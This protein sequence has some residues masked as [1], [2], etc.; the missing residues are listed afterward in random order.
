MLYIFTIGGN[1]FGLG[2]ISRCIPI[3]E[4]WI[5][6][7]FKSKFIV[8]GDNTINNILDGIQFELGDWNLSVL[9]DRIN[10]KQS[11]IIIIDSLFIS[12]SF[13]SLMKRKTKNCTM[14]LKNLYGI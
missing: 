13:I 14:L 5:S 6:R 7:G 8:N 2:H 9:S 12:D 10:L 1:E 4:E 3:Y 11:D